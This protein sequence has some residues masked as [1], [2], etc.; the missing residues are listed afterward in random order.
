M[1]YTRHLSVTA[2]VLV[3]GGLGACASFPENA[4]TSPEVELRDIEVLS[5]SGAP[6]YATRGPNGDSSS[7]TPSHR[8]YRHCR[9]D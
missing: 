6:V 4:I 7:S 9:P 1:N 5:G 2:L 3:L 8:P